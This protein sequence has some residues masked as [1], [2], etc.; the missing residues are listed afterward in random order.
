[1]K[2]NLFFPLFF[3]LLLF[4]ILIRSLKLCSANIYIYC[5]HERNIVFIDVLA[6]VSG[7]ITDNNITLPHQRKGINPRTWKVKPPQT[8]SLVVC[9][10]M[11]PVYLSSFFS[12]F[13]F[14]NNLSLFDM[15]T[16]CQLNTILARISL[17]ICALMSFMKIWQQIMSWLLLCNTITS[18]L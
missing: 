15:Y 8:C 1:M 5:V 3:C 17:L 18:S 13:F 14:A 9:K 16:Q 11:F 12:I 10:I 7:I 4:T 2:I 6:K